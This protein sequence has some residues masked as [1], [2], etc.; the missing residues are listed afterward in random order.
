MSLDLPTPPITVSKVHTKG[1]ESILEQKKNVSTFSSNHFLIIAVGIVARVLWI[2]MFGLGIFINSA[3]YR[4][5]LGK[6]FE[7]ANFLM[8]VFTFTPTNI[9]MLCLLSAFLGGCASLLIIN[10]YRRL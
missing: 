7:W 6:A 4:D 10:K 1:I 9:A 8:S 5:S 2:T 3:P